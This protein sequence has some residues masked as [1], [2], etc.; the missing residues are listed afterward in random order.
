MTTTGFKQRLAA[1]EALLGTFVKTTH[2][3]VVEVLATCGFACLCLDAEHAPFDRQ[4]IDLCLMAAR[5]GGVPALVRPATASPHDILAALDS[6]ADGILAPHIRSAEEATALV[7][8]MHY[9]PGGRGYA[10]STRAAGYGLTPM[11]EHRRAS[12]ERMVAIAQIEDVEALEAIDAVAAVEG[13]D[14]LFI[15]RID[16]TVSLGCASPDDP[17]VEAA[18]GQIVEACVAAGKPVGMFLPRAGD[19]PQWRARGASFFL[20]G[21]DHSMMRA[22]AAALRG[23]AGIG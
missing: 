15:G 2:P 10:G 19:V 1:G 17:L 23:E 5:A 9:G 6:G 4:S 8:A 11:P 16:L 13:V 21:S 3:H 20:L 12:A 14:A 7:K 18:V 22:G